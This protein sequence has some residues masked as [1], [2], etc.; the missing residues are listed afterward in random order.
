[1]HHERIRQSLDNWA[2][3]LAESLHVVAS[4]SVRQILLVFLLSVDSQII[5][6]ISHE[7]SNPFHE[8]YTL[9]EISKTVIPS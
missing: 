2:L 4:G 8:N 5:L 1:M 7:F 9:K 3:S 6:Q